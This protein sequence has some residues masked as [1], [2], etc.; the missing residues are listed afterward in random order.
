MNVC[1]AT[2]KEFTQGKRSNT[3]ENK[4]SGYGC[5]WTRYMIYPCWALWCMP[6]V[7]APPILQRNPGWTSSL[8]KN[9]WTLSK[10]CV[11]ARGENRCW[12]Q[13]GA[14]PGNSSFL[15]QRE[16]YNLPRSI[17]EPYYKCVILLSFTYHS[18]YCWSQLGR[19][20][21]NYLLT[22]RVNGVTLPRISTR[23]WTNFEI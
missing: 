5:I 11:T 13:W 7:K 1:G 16:G 18:P 21:P 10:N 3:R 12:V 23:L 17:Q 22:I 4:L 6:P 14:L 2:I 15:N 20:A 19:H 8:S 9:R